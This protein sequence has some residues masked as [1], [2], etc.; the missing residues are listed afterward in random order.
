VASFPE[1]EQLLIQGAAK[2]KRGKLADSTILPSEEKYVWLFI[3]R[4]ELRH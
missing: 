4:I 2:K 3:H 1:E